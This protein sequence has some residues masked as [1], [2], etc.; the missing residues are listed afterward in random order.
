MANSRTRTCVGRVKF[1]KWKNISNVFYYWRNRHNPECANQLSGIVWKFLLALSLVF[2][3]LI[4]AYSGLAFFKGVT[5]EGEE[6]ILGQSETLSREA[7]SD[8]N[9]LFEQREQRFNYVKRNPPNI[10]DPSR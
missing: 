2:V 4:S 9:D 1:M 5:T 3:I 7:L 10:G 6:S 8:V